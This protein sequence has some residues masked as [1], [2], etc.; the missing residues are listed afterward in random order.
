MYTSSEKLGKDA[1][2]LE[3]AIAITLF[4]LGLIGSI[5]SRSDL[6]LLPFI[7][8][9]LFRVVSLSRQSKI[10]WKEVGNQKAFL[11]AHG[12]VTL[13][14]ILGLFL[15]RDSLELPAWLSDSDPVYILFVYALI[16]ELVFRAYLITKLSYVVKKPALAVL[17]SSLIFALSHLTLPD[18]GLIVGFT[19]VLGL[20]WGWLYL[21]YRNLPLLIAS[22]FLVNWS[23]NFIF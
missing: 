19:F 20:V 15:V 7:L 12:V 14:I 18:S 6:L 13:L 3:L 22:H 21:K 8:F 11:V 1:N 10:Q 17:G 2:A 16:Q 4:V 23:I 9:S 5:W